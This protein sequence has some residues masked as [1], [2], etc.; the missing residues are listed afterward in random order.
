MS[1]AMYVDSELSVDTGDAAAFLVFDDV[2]DKLAIEQDAAASWYA[3]TY[4][5]NV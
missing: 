1:S 4:L 5:I 3:G 2:L